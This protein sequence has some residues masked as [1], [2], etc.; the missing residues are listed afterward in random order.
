MAKRTWTLEPSNSLGLFISHPLEHFSY[1]Q[2]T[3]R[4]RWCMIRTPPA[5]YTCGI[6]VFSRRFESEFGSRRFSAPLPASIFDYCTNGDNPHSIVSPVPMLS[7][8]LEK[9]RDL[10]KWRDS[11]SQIRSGYACEMSS[12]FFG[13]KFSARNDEFFADWNSISVLGKCLVWG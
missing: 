8:L 13:R 3:L 4:N 9:V 1:Y 6:Q 5:V 12:Q 10:A 11:T 7:R 2:E